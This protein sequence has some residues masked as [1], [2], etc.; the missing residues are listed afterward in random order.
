MDFNQ[1]AK[2]IITNVGGAENVSEVE[3]C[4]TRLRFN[5]K[6]A[7][8][9]EKA[10]LKE[11]EGVA[12]VVDQANGVQVIIGTEVSK[13]FEEI[14]KEYTFKTSEV[15]EQ[16][17][18]SNMNPFRRVMNKL[19]DCF[20]PLIP[21]LIAAGLMSA[22]VT[23]ISSFHLMDPASTTYQVLQIMGSAPLYFIPFMLAN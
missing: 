10:T 5:V 3:H 22:V 17:T 20:V 4:S 13:V 16:P 18:D 15:D 8:K 21:A 12:G 19:A 1:L 2:S 14:K 23:L 11:L 9:I 6:D 7:S